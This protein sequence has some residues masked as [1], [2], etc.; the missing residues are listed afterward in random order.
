MPQGASTTDALDMFHRHRLNRFI[1]ANLPGFAGG[2]KGK[3]GFDVDSGLEAPSVAATF[4]TWLEGSPV[5]DS[6]S[7][8]APGGGTAQSWSGLTLEPPSGGWY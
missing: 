5:P 8:G 7:G 1:L 3:S 2:L 6:C 4:E